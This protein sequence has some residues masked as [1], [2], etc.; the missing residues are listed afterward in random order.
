MDVAGDNQ[1]SIEHEM[2]KQRLSQTGALIGTPGMEIIGQ[3]DEA[4]E[5]LPADYC[6]PC[7]GAETPEMKSVALCP[8]C[9]IIFHI[10][11]SSLLF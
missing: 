11:S 9:V 2:I 1:L 6:G 7:Y 5:P 10:I 3:K 4:D 8:I